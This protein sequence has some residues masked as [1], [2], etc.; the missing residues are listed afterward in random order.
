M[1]RDL[2]VAG[3][4]ISFLSV[5][6]SAH[7]AQ[8]AR[9]GDTLR[10]Y[11][12]SHFS[13][14]GTSCLPNAGRNRRWWPPFRQGDNR[15]ASFIPRD[16][17]RWS[18]L[19]E[20][21]DEPV[22]V[23]T[24]Q[25]VNSVFAEVLWRD[26]SDG[27]VDQR[28]A[29][30]PL[31]IT[32]GGP[33]DPI[34]YQQVSHARRQHN[35][36]TLLGGNADVTAELPGASLRMALEATTTRQDS[37]TIFLYG[38]V[39]VSPIAA[40]LGLNTT[41]VDAPAGVSPF[42]VSIAIWHWYD[43]HPDLLARAGQRELVIRNQ[44]EGLAL[45]KV[46]GL[47]QSTLLSGLGSGGISLPFFGVQAQANASSDGSVQGLRRD[48]SAA[49]WEDGS[50]YIALPSPE[51]VIREVQSSAVLLPVIPQGLAVENDRSLSLSVDLVDLPTA[52]CRG[53]FWELDPVLEATDP[54]L[55]A[56]GNL[57]VAPDNATRRCRFTVDVTPPDKQRPDPSAMKVVFRIRT[58]GSVSIGAAGSAVPRHAVLTS[59]PISIPDLRADIG[60]SVAAPPPSVSISARNPTPAITAEYLIRTT[61]SRE[62]TN[63]TGSPSA[64]LACPGSNRTLALERNEDIDLLND[65]T[66][67][68]V[69]ISLPAD[70][71]PPGQ[72]TTECTLGGSAT[73]KTTNRDVVV[74][75]PS[76]TF[77][78][79]RE[80]EPVT[81]SQVDG[82]GIV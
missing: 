8:P 66:R 19:Q 1:K 47:T 80:A 26:L 52:Y 33:S 51:A 15:E 6:G 12:E 4:A 54:S 16:V 81:T 11:L 64:L 30:Q 5:F 62:V 10:S 23:R 72:T 56:N 44:V 13:E 35:C 60:L 76:T 29:G 40:V 53:A 77:R 25:S 21:M 42:A 65:S 38:G 48:Y 69:Q 18:I 46:T 7:A 73:L 59:P 31:G 14:V 70:V 24:T 71:I 9:Q 79:T 36:I 28:S 55:G 82:G 41:A 78:V 2:T 34:L 43:Q 61:A 50:T 37:Q 67:L 27:T 17:L 22:K 74:S 58:R 32:W 45:Y 39:M 49:L 75:F 20:H 3:V 57:S 63:L 68:R